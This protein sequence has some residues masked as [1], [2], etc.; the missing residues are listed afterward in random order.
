MLKMVAGIQYL[1]GDWESNTTA[2]PM[3][4][5]TEKMTFSCK[6][7]CTLTKHMVL[8]IF[9]FAVFYFQLRFLPKLQRLYS[10]STGTQFSVTNSYFVEK[11]GNEE[12]IYQVPVLASSKCRPAI[13]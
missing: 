4:G 1:N 8:D 6:D 7:D 9:R 3:C 13:A 2:L 10:S 12:G 5:Q 11:N